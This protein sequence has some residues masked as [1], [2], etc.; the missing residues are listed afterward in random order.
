MIGIRFALCAAALSMTGLRSAAAQQRYAVADAAATRSDSIARAKVARTGDSRR[1]TT[2]QPDDRTATAGDAAEPTRV[3][4]TPVTV[5]GTPGSLEV[6]GVPIPSA[7]GSPDTI[8]YRIVPSFGV[9]LL[10]RTQGMFVAGAPRPSSLMITVAAPA[11]AAAGR[12]RVASAQ[13]DGTAGSAPLEVPIEMT[14]LAVRRVELTVVDQLVGARRGDIATIRYRA[15]NFGNVGDS[16]T[17]SAELPVGWRLANG[18]LR[19]MA[20]PV[21]AARDGALR[22]YVPQQ[23]P[24]GT[25]MLRIVAA[26]QGSIVAAVDVR[27]EVENP[28]AIAS[29]LGPR[30]TVGSAFGS[31]GGAS[32]TSAYVATLEGQLSDSVS[33]SARGTW[34]P[35]ASAGNNG[36]D[37][38]LMRL[39]VP[40]VP[41][42]L[43]L[44]APAFR[45]GL[46]LTGGALSDLT[47]SYLSGT[48][49]SL[50]SRLGEWR[51][52]GVAARP[53]LYGSNPIDT[54]AQGEI[55][56]A[57][58]EHPI[59]SGALSITAT[60]ISDPGIARQLD[61][62]SL[63]ASFEGTPIGDFTSEMGYRR[64]SAGAGLGWSAELRR[65]TE[66]G[67]FSF[68][69]IHAPGGVVAYARATDDMSAAGS[70]RFADWLALSGAYWRSGD[71]SSVLGSSSGSGWNAG[72]TFSSHSLGANLSVQARGSSI[73]VTGQQGSFG[74]GES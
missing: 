24:P 67:S 51:M 15:V 71:V 65:Q 45:L 64:Y 36:M 12:V 72:P 22:V 38:A 39:G 27:V 69:T 58:V 19:T 3:T 29:Q 18:G 23:A 30:L 42:S 49:I 37:F 2:R 28:S 47:G 34:R 52:S 7:L 48:G 1:A 43:S 8:R 21:R 68:R 55:A 41:A 9:R 33:I 40:M 14:V 35:S 44:T 5:S 53:Y 57:R 13:F 26:S 20:L 56:N 6:V 16:I 11:S 60:H 62:G 50:G 70:R 74:N 46:G 17:L 4:L 66:N 59:G 73:G 25:S 31:L 32:T 54:A 61:A 10:G 63:G